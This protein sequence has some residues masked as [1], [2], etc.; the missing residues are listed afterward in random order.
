ME[1]YQHNTYK[2]IYV[3]REHRQRGAAPPGSANTKN[4]LTDT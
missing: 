4:L 2:F 1:Q 3:C